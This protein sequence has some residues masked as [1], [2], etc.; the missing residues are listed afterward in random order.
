MDVESDEEVFGGTPP[1]IVL[2]AK[3]VTLNLLPEKSRK[4]YEKAY[5]CFIKWCAEKSVSS[6]TENVLLTHFSEQS[7]V[8]KASS[9]WSY[10]SK[11]KSMLL[12]NHNVD[13]SKFP[14]LIVFLK[15]N[16]E[17]YKPKKSKVLS[18]EQVFKFIHDAPND[19]YL[20]TKVFVHF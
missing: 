19:S 6:Y 2:A 17:G 4:L 16:S 5:G 18:R 12:I 3:E 14:K 8:Y 10:Y 7:K 11:I 13:I 15:R 1:E 9:L 20:M